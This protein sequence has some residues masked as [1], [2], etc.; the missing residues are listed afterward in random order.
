MLPVK[1]KAA[2]LPLGLGDLKDSYLYKGLVAQMV[3]RLPAIRETQVQSL[4]W[5]D[6]LEKATHSSIL[7]G[8]SHRQWSLVCYSPW[9]RKEWDTTERLHFTST[10]IFLQN[11]FRGITR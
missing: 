10:F 5:E 1:F 9:G 4:G 11:D 7:A 6:L 8:K 3:K 2:S